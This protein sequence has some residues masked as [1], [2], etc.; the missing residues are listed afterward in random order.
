MTLIDKDES[1]KITFSTA[2]KSIIAAL[3]TISAIGGTFLAFDRTYAKISDAHAI[4]LDKANA[5]K[6]EVAQTLQSQQKMYETQQQ[7]NSARLLEI[8][9]CQRIDLQKQIS[10]EP[11]NFDLKDSLDRIET[12]IRTLE[13]E[14]YSPKNVK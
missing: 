3:F 6:I 1:G 13:S 14:V 4:A 7:I 5:A 9:R 12:Q 8:L 11:S 2:F 10:K